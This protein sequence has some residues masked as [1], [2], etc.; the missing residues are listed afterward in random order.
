[1][2]LLGGI[3]VV[4]LRSGGTALELGISTAVKIGTVAG[5]IAGEKSRVGVVAGLGLA[6]VDVAGAIRRSCCIFLVIRV[7]G[8]WIEQDRSYSRTGHHGVPPPQ[9]ILCLLI[10]VYAHYRLR[11]HRKAVCSEWKTALWLAQRGCNVLSSSSSRSLFLGV[12]PGWFGNFLSSVDRDASETG[13]TRVLI[14]CHAIHSNSGTCSSG[15]HA[16]GA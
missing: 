16:R 12:D 8:R 2:R 6:R 15:T 7:G 5:A 4:A 14:I 13:L 11:L 1:M 9:C 3:K 10:T